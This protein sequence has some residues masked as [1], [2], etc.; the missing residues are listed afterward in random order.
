VRIDP[1]A[2]QPAWQGCRAPTAPVSFVTEPVECGHTGS[3]PCYA[4]PAAFAPGTGSPLLRSFM[5]K[6]KRRAATYQYHTTPVDRRHPDPDRAARGHARLPFGYAVLL[7]SFR[8]QQ[9]IMEFLS[10]SG[11]SR[12]IQRQT[13][14]RNER[15]KKIEEGI[16]DPELV[17]VETSLG[18]Q[19]CADSNQ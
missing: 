14:F 8:T 2:W 15:K 1:D 3:K 11:V 13:A 12:R 10:L 6:Y 5:A 16:G 4:R 9:A 19:T 7:T 18:V 17:V